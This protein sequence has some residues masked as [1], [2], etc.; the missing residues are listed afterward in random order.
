[1]QCADLQRYL[2]AYLDLRLGRSRGAI[3]RRHLSV[4]PDC[5]ARVENLRQFERDL[6]RQF[7]AMARASSVWNGLEPT[8]VRSGGLAEAPPSLPFLAVEPAPRALPP[9]S[10]A[11]AA[12]VMPGTTATPPP[13]AKPAAT[14]SRWGRRMIGLVMVAAA[15]GAAF[16]LWRSWLSPQPASAEVRAFLSYGEGAD[17]VQFRTEDARR[18]RGWFAGRLGDGFP[19]PPTPAAFRL[20]GGRLERLA[21]SQSATIVYQRDGEPA[22]L[23]VT[24]RDSSSGAAR[25]P[26]RADTVDGISQLGWD[27]ARFDYALVS[28]LPAA[29]L[30]AFAAVDGEPF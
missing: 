12:R 4:C 16:Q 13:S 30:A 28:R 1:M 6:Q 11:A 24:P 9:P 15:A 2:E 8:L 26:L 21:E 3:L 5:R 10:G 22:L 25:R 29:E 18:L 7:R 19:E 17:G 27:G 14:P 20:V 23:F